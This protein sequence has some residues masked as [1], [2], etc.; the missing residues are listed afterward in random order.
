MSHA[1]EKLRHYKSIPIVKPCDEEIVLEYKHKVL[2]LFL[3]KDI[4][5]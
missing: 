1:K 2:L 4:Q 5:I 3:E